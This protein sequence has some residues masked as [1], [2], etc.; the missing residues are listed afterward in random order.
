LIYLF[1]QS[2]GDKSFLSVRHYSNEIGFAGVVATLG[3]I[4]SQ[5]LLLIT[6]GRTRESL[7]SDDDG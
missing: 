1:I 2:A 7:P 3:G 4:V 5:K 6:K